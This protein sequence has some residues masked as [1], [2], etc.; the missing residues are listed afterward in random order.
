MDYTSYIAPERRSRPT[1]ESL[2]DEY[3]NA[4]FGT[5]SGEF[6]EFNILKCKNPTSLPDIFNRMRLTLWDAAEVHC[7]DGMML[8]GIC[9]MGSISVSVLLFYDYTTE[10]LI[11]YSDTAASRAVKIGPNLLDGSTS[12]SATKH[13]SMRF[14]T[15]LGNGKAILSGSM[16]DDKG[17][18]R[19][20]LELK[21][22]S[23]PSVVSMP[24]GP[25]RPVYTE[26]I[27]FSCTGSIQIGDRVIDM[28]PDAVA[29]IDDHR[30]Y[31]PRRMHYDWLC[32]LGKA[33]VG[34]ENRY[35]AF[36]L[37]KN[38]STDP[39]KYNE[40]LIWLEGRQSL[41]PPVTFSKEPG[42]P[43]YKSP[44]KWHVRDTH[45]MVDLEFEVLGTHPT[46]VS[47]GVVDIHYYILF[48]K[49]TG[50][51]KLEDGTP[52]KLDHVRAVGEDKTMLF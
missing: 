24:M 27:F 9:D 23:P 36:N 5:F 4:A 51:L 19:Y 39:V 12:Y 16:Q 15:D 35:F 46:I 10:E 28:D 31:Y 20:R 11:S 32:T 33:E 13:G 41:L 21:K 3:G 6:R 18:M 26:K 17:P 52:I 29:I 49:V 38:Q 8:C 42:M 50:T 14:V 7:R 45:G 2:V 34:G 22:L 43:D 40:N 30:G 44:A 1:P 37:T 47:A 48:G 25:N